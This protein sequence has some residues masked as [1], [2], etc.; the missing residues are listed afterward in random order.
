MSTAREIIQ[1]AYDSIGRGSSILAT[2]TTLIDRALLDLISILEDLRLNEIILE[3]TVSGVTTTISTPSALDDALNEPKA[4]RLHLVNLLAAHVA[5]AARANPADMQLVPP[6]PYSRES[7]TRLYRKHV[8]PNKVPSKLLP[9][10]QGARTDRMFGVFFNGES[11]D[12][13]ATAT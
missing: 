4:S 3:E 5:A 1:D 12:D 9:R 6:I 7:L 10:G 11:I 13:D 8:I 2:D